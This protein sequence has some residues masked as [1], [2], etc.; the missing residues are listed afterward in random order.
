MNNGKPDSL[1]VLLAVHV[2]FPEHFY[3]TETYTLD[4]AKQ[5]INRGHE[6]VVLT[7]T[8]CGEKGSGRD[9]ECYEYEGV[10]VYRIDLNLRPHSRFKDTYYRKDL[11]PL[12][13]E[14]ITEIDPHIAHVTH[15]IN[16]TAVLLEILKGLGIPTVATLTDFYGICFNNKLERYD[17]TLCNGPNRASTNCLACYLKAISCQNKVRGIRK[18]LLSN[19]SLLRISAS[20]L[21]FLTNAPG[22][23]KGLLA[24]QV[25]DVT[26][27]TKTLRH[28]YGIYERMI[29]P[30]D[31]L[32][33]A[34]KKNGFYPE[35]LVKINFGIELRRVRE[36]SK[37]KACK[38]GKTVFGYIGQIAP[39]KGVD[40]LVNAFMALAGDHGQ[41]VLYGPHDQDPGYMTELQRLARGNSAVEFAGTF[42]PKE[43]GRRLSE[44]DVLV[45]PS[46]WY[47]NSPLVLLYALASKTPVIVSDVKG[48]SEFVIDGINGYTFKKDDANHLRI[49][50]Q[51]LLNHPER[52]ARLSNNSSYDKD[53][54]DYADEVL[55]IY[56]SVLGN[57]SSHKGLTQ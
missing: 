39:H 14:I 27:R 13:R 24:G 36:V 17:G 43:L 46:R 56:Q 21:R 10:K 15:L 12:L 52:L 28:L 47:E 8:P 32:Y 25:M 55:N 34:Y 4:L 29:A 11:A 57:H 6:P 54:S 22:L 2:F 30:T 48:L 37:E 5:L 50:M 23:N 41:L 7:A 49:I 42:P 51:D 45:I 53:V 16:H 40:L 3:G 38:R 33:E 20:G 35:R 18:F 1:K 31:F 19:N 9:W 44:L 26:M